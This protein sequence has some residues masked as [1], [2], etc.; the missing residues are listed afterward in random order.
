[1]TVSAVVSVSTPHG[2][3]YIE[4]LCKHWEHKF[5]VECTNCRGRIFLPAGACA[6]LVAEAETLNVV[7][8]ALDIEV[9]ERMEGV[10]E[11]HLRRLAYKEDLQT[12]AWRSF[13]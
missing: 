13:A 7:L 10:I 11:T 4:R 8:E 3:Q 6:T 9:L 1:V 5:Q 2:S 12:F